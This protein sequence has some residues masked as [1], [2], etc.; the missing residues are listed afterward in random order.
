M[1]QSKFVRT[2]ICRSRV[3]LAR[4]VAL[5]LLLAARSVFATTSTNGYIGASCMPSEPTDAFSLTG[6]YGFVA[7]NTEHVVCPIV[8]TTSGPSVASGDSIA[9]V[10]ITINNH[11]HSPGI[12]CQVVTYSSLVPATT[13]PPPPFTANVTE[14]TG[15][16]SGSMGTIMFSSFS[17]SAWWQTNTW[18]YAQLECLLQNGEELTSYSV[19]ENGT[20]TGDHLYP[21]LALCTPDSGSD[22][23]GQY[24]NEQEDGTG[25]QT[26]FVLADGGETSNF[27]YSCYL[28]GAT[29]QFSMLPCDNTSASWD[30]SFSDTG[31]W[32]TPYAES[33][34]GQSN[35]YPSY[36][37]PSTTLPATG[38]TVAPYGFLDTS[39]EGGISFQQN[40]TTGDMGIV[41]IRTTGE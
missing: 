17:T 14:N 40:S 4:T 23:R 30:W 29:A 20:D 25:I 15:I 5:L 6:A 34:S 12:S 28:P 10:S 22:P 1:S 2:V 13:T 24:R 39:S 19:T 33:G 27:F 3:S 38:F 11:G 7:S 9:S 21:A 16:S 37:F 32:G 41:S 36:N 26:G 8:K 18:N 31:P 35:A